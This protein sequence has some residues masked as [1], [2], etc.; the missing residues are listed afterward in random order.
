MLR[1]M[2]P[3]VD[4]RD[5][6]HALLSLVFCEIATIAGADDS[7]WMSGLNACPIF[8]GNDVLQCCSCGLYALR[9][10]CDNAHGLSCL[11][12]KLSMACDDMSIAIIL[13]APKCAITAAP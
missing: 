1:T 10:L 9:P 7:M 4:A 6:L 11:L 5:A 13:A 2:L 12:I 3:F 8:C